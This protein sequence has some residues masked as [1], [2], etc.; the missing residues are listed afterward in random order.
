MQSY[1]EKYGG[2]RE[3]GEKE[4]FERRKA[5]LDEW[6]MEVKYPSGSCRLL[7]CPEDKY[8]TNTSC[9]TGH[10]ICEQCQIPQCHECKNSMY[11][12]R[13]RAVMPA[14]ALA[15]DM[16]IFYAPSILYT[17]RV[18]V[19]EMVCA[20]VCLT[21]MICF[22]LEK[23]YRGDRAF[24]EG[25]HMNNH[26]MGARGN[27]TSFPLPWQDLFLQLQ[28]T[29]QDRRMC[30]GPELPRSGDELSDFVSVLLKTSDDGDTEASLAHFVHQAVVRRDVVIRLITELHNCGHVA[31]KNIDMA[32]MRL[33]AYE[34]LPEN[35]IP[36]H[37]AKLLPYDSSLDNIQVQKQATPVAAHTT[38][39]KVRD[40]FDMQKPNAVVLEKSSCDESDINAQRIAAVRVFASKLDVPIPEE[41][42][43]DVGSCEADA[44][45]PSGKRRKVRGGGRWCTRL[46]AVRIAGE[47]EKATCGACGV[48]NRECNDR[49]V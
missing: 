1:L 40:H 43:A 3:A 24:D 14:A 35:G 47:V 39:E 30:T 33:K 31:Y 20:S 36:A 25:V 46:D 48:C 12:K 37:V 49:S 32:K 6:N 22:S 38:L 44:E 2:L 26:R 29:D 9:M 45:A 28:K 11:D 4:L 16:M 27:A 13:G 21:S 15:N 17:E 23:K 7:G 19:M 42:E 5:E 8:C 41:V 34:T 10:D 18:T